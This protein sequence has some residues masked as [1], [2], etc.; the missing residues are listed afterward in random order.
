MSAASF[1]GVTL[2]LG[3]RIVLSG[4]DLTVPA[5]SFTGLLGPN[6]AGKTT[7][8][9]AM[10]GLL[11]PAC[12]QITVLGAAARPG[13]PAIGYLPQTRPSHLPPLC[14]A[15]VLA[16]SQNGARWGVPLPTRAA[17]AEIAWALAQTGAAPFAA[18]RL[19][20]L[21][22]GERQRVLIAQALLG[23]PKLLLL[24]E[25]LAGLD[26]RHQVEIVHLLADLRARLGITV[27]CSAHDLDV[28]LPVLDQVLYTAGGRAALGPVD[29]VITA[30][31]LT[32]LYGAPVQVIRAG[33][34]V[35]VLPGEA[36]R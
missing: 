18:R 19:T 3:G 26:P 35:F 31:A 10:L 20:E 15:D 36:P 25:P 29:A 2:A 9:R 5:G 6:G 14:A 4:I 12:G 13:N 21:S 22:G 33:G 30:P 24:D 1:A 11:P 32:A 17:R 34:R 27:L 23:R 16:A 7:L 28:L 8:L